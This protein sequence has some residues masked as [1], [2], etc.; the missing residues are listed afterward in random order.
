MEREEMTTERLERDVGDVR[1][2]QIE[3]FQLHT[4][5][6]NG[7][8]TRITDQDTAMQGETGQLRGVLAEGEKGGGSDVGAARE[9]DFNQREEV[10]MRF[11]HT[12]LKGHAFRDHVRVRPQLQTAQGRNVGADRRYQRVAQGSSAKRQDV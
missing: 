3:P 12:I 11:D 1:T 10:E 8:Y 9:I 5:L 4:S 6:R 7:Q 2:R